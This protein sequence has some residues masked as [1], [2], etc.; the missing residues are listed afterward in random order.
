MKSCIVAVKLIALLAVS[1]ICV[2]CF[3]SKPEDLQAFLRPDEAVIT[4]DDYILQPPD[5]IT[6]ISSKIPELQGTT[7]TVGHTQTIRPDG[8]I[9][10]ETVGEVQAAGKTPREVA[11]I[12]AQKMA[13]LY[14]LTSDYPVDVRAVNRSKY[15]Y[16]LGQVNEPGAKIFS[17]R[18]TTLSAIA[19]ANPNP[20][21]WEE[22][23][24]VI[25]PSLDL[26]KEPKIFEFNYERMISHGEMK[27]NVLLQEGDI[28]YVPPTILGA[29]G[30]TVEEIV[31]PL[32]Q[33]ATAARTISPEL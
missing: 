7:Q 21:A 18:E 10:F 4:A 1:I 22:R 32:F 30:L 14:N 9:S 15:Y 16:I 25:R 13:A 17:G 3:S 11:K 8:V 5:V 26:S 19:K 20:R 24:Q 33:S 23:V 12:I 28:I 27:Y 31:G 29:V 2:G 6:V